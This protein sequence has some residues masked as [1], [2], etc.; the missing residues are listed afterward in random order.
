MECRAA[1]RRRPALAHDDEADHGKQVE[2][3][4][5]NALDIDKADKTISKKLDTIKDT[6]LFAMERITWSGDMPI[7]H[8]RLIFAPGYRMRTEI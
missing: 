1:C 2:R 4:T 3:Q 7:T 8:V 5:G 6:A